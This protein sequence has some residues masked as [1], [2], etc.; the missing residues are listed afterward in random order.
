LQSARVQREEY[1]GQ[2]LPEPLVTNERSDALGLIRVDET[3]SMAFL[4]L[5]ERLTAFRVV[6]R[7][8]ALH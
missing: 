7:C 8:G 6:R 1:V 5:L 3:L 4:V 2:W